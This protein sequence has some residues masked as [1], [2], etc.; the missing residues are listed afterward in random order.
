MRGSAIQGPGFPWDSILASME[1]SVNQQIFSG[2]LCQYG[3]HH[4]S[5]YTTMLEEPYCIRYA[6]TLA[7]KAS[8]VLAI[9]TTTPLV[10]FPKPEEHTTMVNT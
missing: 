10:A 1:L 3:A 8:I 6:E 4:Q 2:P 9:S 7:A 5:G